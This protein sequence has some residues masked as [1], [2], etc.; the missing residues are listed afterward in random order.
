MTHLRLS[1]ASTGAVWEC[2]VAGGV[3]TLTLPALPSDLETKG[4]T[5]GNAVT[6]QVRTIHCPGLDWRAA[7]LERLVLEHTGE[8]RTLPAV[9]VP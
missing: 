3:T 8:S 1:D 7:T 9:F 4:L 2:W 5:P 6:W